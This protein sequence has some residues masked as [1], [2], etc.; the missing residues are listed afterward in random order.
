MVSHG[1]VRSLTVLYDRLYDYTWTLHPCQFFKS[2]KNHTR[3]SRIHSIGPR[4]TRIRPRLV[5]LY[6]RFTQI[7]NRISRVFCVKKLPRN[8]IEKYYTWVDVQFLIFSQ[9]PSLFNVSRDLILSFVSY[10]LTRGNMFYRILIYLNCAI[11]T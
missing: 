11:C 8:V 2:F 7:A 10:N 3:L 5:L 6:V 1:L 4:V 9:F